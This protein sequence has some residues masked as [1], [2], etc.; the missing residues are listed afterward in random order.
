MSTVFLLKG[1]KLTINKGVFSPNPGKTN[2]TL[3]LLNNMPDVKGKDILDMGCG[4]GVIGIFC[5]LNGAMHVVAADV[6]KRAVENAKENATIKVRGFKPCAS[7][8]DLF[9]NI[10]GRFDF[11]FGNLPI[12]DSEWD[13]G[14]STIVL[15]KKFVSGCR[16]HIRKDGQAF[17]TWNSESDVS[18]VISFLLEG[19]YTFTQVAEKRNGITWYLFKIYF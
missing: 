12:V 4:S 11:V 10:K 5:A 13:L 17:F 16:Q 3:M 8:S 7:Q 15:L 1:V 18:D 19:K 9:K 2:S 6:D 14:V